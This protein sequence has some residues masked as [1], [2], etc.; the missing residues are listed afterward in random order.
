MVHGGD[1]NAGRISLRV[2]SCTRVHRPLS[3]A[4]S[5]GRSINLFKVPKIGIMKIA[6]LLLSVVMV[7]LLVAGQGKAEEG[8]KVTIGGK[9][10]GATGRHTVRVLLWR[11]EQFLERPVQTVA[12]PPGAA[13]GFSF[14]VPPGPWAVS[15]FED[16]N[17]NGVLDIGL[18][19]PKEPNAFWRPF[20]AQRAPKFNEVALAVAGDTTGVEIRLK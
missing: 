10:S 17:E 1:C 18:F 8:K 19:G 5:E 9:V 16:K 14:S 20:A 2:I 3:L 13:T 15:A 4:L 12:L 6:S 11:S 7:G